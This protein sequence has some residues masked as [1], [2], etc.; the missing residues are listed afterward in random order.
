MQV[1]DLEA[2]FPNNF[3]TTPDFS[4]IIDC[5]TDIFVYILINWSSLIINAWLIFDFKRF[6]A[7][8]SPK[9]VRRGGEECAKLFYTHYDRPDWAKVWTISGQP[10]LRG[11][12]ATLHPFFTQFFTARP[13]AQK[14]RRDGWE[15]QDIK[16]LA[17]KLAQGNVEREKESKKSSVI[18]PNRSVEVLLIIIISL[19]SFLLLWLLIFFVGR[20]GEQFQIQQT[21]KNCHPMER[22]N[23]SDKMLLLSL[24]IILE[25]KVWLIAFYFF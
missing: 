1:T 18:D 25:M 12:A 9:S 15:G 16:S 5:T 2:P 4:I 22:V 8:G 14:G 3:I 17:A 21:L 7:P 23:F 20:Y 24:L 11:E 6:L 13:I 19:P 10:T